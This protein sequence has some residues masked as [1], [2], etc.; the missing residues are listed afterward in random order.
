LVDVEYSARTAYPRTDQ[1]S[2]IEVLV[3]VESQ[4]SHR[5]VLETELTVIDRDCTVVERLNMTADTSGFLRGG[6]KHVAVGIEPRLWPR[7]DNRNP[8]GTDQKRLSEMES[9]LPDMV[10][11]LAQEKAVGLVGFNKLKYA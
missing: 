5:R 4:L 11:S 9:P 2:E 3:E 10:G 1:P 8:E 7:L 6:E